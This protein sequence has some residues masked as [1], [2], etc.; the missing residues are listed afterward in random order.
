M[1]RCAFLSTED[2]EGFAVY[3]H[4]AV[5]ALNARGWS[6]DEVPWR[7]DVDWN[8]YEVVVVRSTWD[9]QSDAK[10]FLER[11]ERIEASSATLENPLDVLRWNIDKRYLADLEARGAAI[12]PSL[13]LDAF[14]ADAVAGAFDRFATKRLVV[15]P[16]ISAN[17]DD[18]F[19]VDAP[20]PSL[21]ARFGARGLLVQPFVE[22]VAATGEHSLF[23][24]DGAYSH[25]VLKT[26]KADDFRV[27]EEH[28]GTLALVEPSPDL[29][30]AGARALEAI[31]ERLLYARVDL[32][33]YRGA[34]VVMEVELIEPSLYFNMDDGAAER[35][36][37]ALTARRGDGPPPRSAARSPDR[38]S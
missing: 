21:A 35:F 8:A 15:K 24:F 30:A 11:L 18:T 6:V 29:R 23:Y 9:Y 25:C 26:P 3:D 14:D 7:A 33:R 38:R 19:V 37:A 5:P 28:G 34:P 13:F 2:L 17:A 32:V 20:D 16:R 36:A 12:V 27:Q 31:G 22:D 1:R 10:A 4:L